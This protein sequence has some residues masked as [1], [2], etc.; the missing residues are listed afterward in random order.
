MSDINWAALAAPIPPQLIK[1]RKVGGGGTGNYI[2]ARTVMNRLD[3]VVGPAHW[4]DAYTQGQ[5]GTVI[6]TLFIRVDG[7]WVGKSDVGTESNIE[8]DKG[9]FSD[10]LKRAAVKWGIGRELY[11]DGSVYAHLLKQQGGTS[12]PAA[13]ETP[14]PPSETQNADATSTPPEPP[15][16]APVAPR[17]APKQQTDEF[18]PTIRQT[19]PDVATTLL[20]MAIADLPM[21]VGAIIY[22]VAVAKLGY[23]DDDAVKTA[24]NL[25]SLKDADGTLEDLMN[26][27]IIAS[28]VMASG[29]QVLPGTP[30]RAPKN[31][32]Q[33]AAERSGIAAGQ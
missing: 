9:A 27:V 19:W 10:A 31:A 8:E 26:A 15:S 16:P 23:T 12:G 17:T 33:T 11:G 29:Q 13:T 2:T 20:K 4:Y 6:C 25:A 1:S 3:G 28:P 7:E 5:D 22:P 32:G 30:K 18:G 24:L 21:P 14:A